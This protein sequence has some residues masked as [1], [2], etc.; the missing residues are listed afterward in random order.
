MENVDCSPNRF[1]DFAVISSKF[2]KGPGLLL[3]NVHNG[4]DRMTNFELPSERMVDQFHACLFL[5]ML[6]GG[7]EEHLKP[8][9]RSV[10]H[11]TDRI[12]AV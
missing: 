7:V 12:Y 1:H 2:G 9:A 3:E 10:S 11:H 4:V 8:E 6:H 5:I